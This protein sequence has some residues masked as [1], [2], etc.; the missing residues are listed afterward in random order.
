MCIFQRTCYFNSFAFKL[1]LYT[2]K[3]YNP[4]V[5]LFFFFIKPYIFF[6]SHIDLRLICSLCVRFGLQKK[7]ITKSAV[8]VRMSDF[9]FCSFCFMLHDASDS[10]SLALKQHSVGVKTA[11]I[12]NKA[13]LSSFH[14]RKHYPN[15]LQLHQKSIY[16][17][18]C[19]QSKLL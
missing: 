9:N 2:Y 19:L 16:F 15:Y 10:N 3:A 12:K 1:K 18:Q 7:C 6:S 13:L 11:L 4:L 5:C 17:S 8:T 14:L